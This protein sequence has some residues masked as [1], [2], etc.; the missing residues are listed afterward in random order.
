M[1]AKNN[2]LAKTDSSSIVSSSVE[3]LPVGPKIDF[4]ENHLGQEDQN[5]VNRL[6]LSTKDNFILEVSQTSMG[7]TSVRA[8]AD[9]PDEYS[10]SVFRKN[11]S[12]KV[13]EEPSSRRFGAR[14]ESVTLHFD[15]GNLGSLSKE[16]MTEVA[17]RLGNPGTNFS[18]IRVTEKSTK[19][20]KLFAVGVNFQGKVDDW[21]ARVAYLEVEI[22]QNS[23]LSGLP[24]KSLGESTSH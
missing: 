22:T 9:N 16:K 19:K 11:N 14:N 1:E 3:I 5:F 4:G 12:N 23:K 2:G 17:S 7:G 21:N 18:L 6:K 20:S 15:V 10:I 13:I 8:E 24:Q